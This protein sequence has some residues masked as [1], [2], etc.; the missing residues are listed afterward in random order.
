MNRTIGELLAKAG[1]TIKPRDATLLLSFVLK[2]P[3]T[4]VMARPERQ[5][6]TAYRRAFLHLVNKRAAGI[7]LA[8]LTGRKEF[9]GLNFIVNKNVLIPR[10]ETETMVEAAIEEIESRIMNYEL[11]NRMLLIDVG[12]GSGCIPVAIAKT[13]ER[14]NGRTKERKN[15]P[16]EIFAA[17]ISAAALRV[18]RK[19]AS[20]HSAAMEFIRGDLLK[21]IVK[22]LKSKNCKLKTINSI[23]LTANLPYLTL[24]QLREEPTIRLEPKTALL[25]GGKDGLNIYRKL[26]KQIIQI[27]TAHS[28]ACRR[29]GSKL[30]AF[31]E[32]DPSQSAAMYALIQRH[33]PAA[34]IAVKK[35]LAGRARVISFRASS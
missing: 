4:A 31:F 12:T 6:P 30:T 22:I 11:W 32:I 2:M 33:L 15:S 34:E 23:I 18:A 24:R 27:L 5:A 16:I 14:R 9:Y 20:R 26:L 17:D 10:P 29:G 25:G 21:P 7:P 1:Q 28:P 19:N 35:D 13:I 3:E 8:Y